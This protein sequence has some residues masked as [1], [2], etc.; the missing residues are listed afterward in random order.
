MGTIK[1][2]TYKKGLAVLQNYSDRQRL[3][4]INLGFD[5]DNFQAKFHGYVNVV[6]DDK[7]KTWLYISDDKDASSDQLFSCFG[8]KVMLGKKTIFELDVP[9]NLLYI[10]D[11]LAG[12]ELQMVD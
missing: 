12:H 4:H 1:T 9:R 8:L 7:G 6:C 11:G 10:Q 5:P 2:L 3:V